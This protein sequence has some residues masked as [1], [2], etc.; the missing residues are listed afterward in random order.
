MS[1]RYNTR[2]LPARG[3]VTAPR[4]FCASGIAAGIK[5]ADSTDLGLIHSK[6]PCS[7]AGVFTTNRIRAASVD[8]SERLLPS[9]HIHAVCC[10]SGNANACTGEQGIRDVRS[11]AERVAELL[12]TDPRSVLVAST[13]VIGELLP[14]D[15]MISAL[16][17]SAGSLSAKNGKR[18]ARAILTTDTVT[19]E[20]ALKA[21]V[22]GGSVV[23]GGCAKGSG[24]IHPNMA[25]ML[26]FITTDVSIPAAVLK[27]ILKRVVDGTFNNLSVDGD[28]STNDM[29][30]VL[31]NG[32]SGVNISGKKEIVMFHEMLFEVCDNLCAQ[33][34]ADGEGATKRI[35]IAVAGGRSNK[36]CKL[37]AKAVANSNLVKT[38]IFG[39]DP[40][41]GRIV[42]AVG[43]SGA[44]F[45]SNRLS[46][47]LCGIPVFAQSRPT[48]FSA[49]RMRAA[50]R[51]KIIPIGIDLGYSAGTS[52]IAHTC[53]LTYDY[54]RINA[55]YRT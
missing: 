1:K 29:V 7:A 10:N 24:M 14:I 36:H 40:N 26:G 5:K 11:T 52:A 27:R 55:E 50:L 44:D 32:C 31:A 34:A 6:S 4:G 47:S 18:F 51:R 42:C 3:G 41:W 23:I 16:P 54:I 19:K 2:F 38:A 17:G 53:D 8:W 12:D 13:G 25:T 15:R 21:I 45:S 22:P 49:K 28:T 9:S 37:A 35:E 48:P 43:Y 39:N 30:L 46:V 33:I 20:Y